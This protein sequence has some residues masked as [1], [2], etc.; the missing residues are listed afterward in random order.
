MST[1]ANL[2]LLDEPTVGVD[3]RAKAEIYRVI[4]ELAAQGAA[5][6][7]FSTDLIELQGITDRI[8]ILARG[9]LVRELVSKETSHQEILGWA[10]AAGSGSGSGSSP[11]A[12]AS[13]SSTHGHEAVQA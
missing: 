8:L 12:S 10:S 1:R 7:L 2:Y 3:I 5:V 4:D 6:L 9:K 13:A 11:S